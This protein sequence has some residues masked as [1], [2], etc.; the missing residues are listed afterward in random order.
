MEASA[1]GAAVAF[2]VVFVLVSWW[3]IRK[4]MGFWKEEPGG[5]GDD[6]PG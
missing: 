4:A 2:V 3:G 5:A 6:S 1:V